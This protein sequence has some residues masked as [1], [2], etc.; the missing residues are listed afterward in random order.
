MVKPP[1]SGAGYVPAI[2]PVRAKLRSGD[3]RA[4]VKPE[5]I[6]FMFE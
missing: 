5:H 3:S 6:R 1:G 2:D 4:K